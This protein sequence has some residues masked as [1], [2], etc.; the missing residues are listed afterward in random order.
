MKFTDY[1]YERPDINRFKEE[2]EMIL[3]KLM[4]ENN[5]NRF[6]KYFLEANKIF[7]NIET[8]FTLSK[9][10]NSLDVSDK[11]Y[12]DEIVFR[13]EN[14]PILDLY[15]AK[16]YRI[17]MSSKHKELLIKNYGE[18]IIEIARI[19]KST[20]SENI[21][22]ESEEENKLISSYGKL[23]ST[24]KV[25]YEG[26]DLR[27]SELGVY[28]TSPDRKI[29]KK[30]F[31]AFDNFFENKKNEFDYIYDSIIK[32]RNDMA[33]K[34]GYSNFVSLAYDRL[35]RYSYNQGDI[36]KHRELIKIYI[37]PLANTIIEEQKKELGFEKLYYYDENVMFLDSEAKLIVNEKN[38]INAA[39]E[40]YEEMSSET[41]EFF[42]YME[43]SKN[44]DLESRDN[45]KW[46]AFCAF[47]P[48]FKTPFVY[49][50]F[51]NTAEDV[52]LLT[53][54]MGHGFQMYRS[55][56]FDLPEYRFPT[57]DSC[58]VHSMSMEFLSYPFMDK[59]F[60]EDA[61]KFKFSHL[62]QYI[63]FIPYC[64]LIDDFQ[65]FIYEN[66][67]CT[68][69]ERNEYYKK[70]EK[71][72][73]PYRNYDDLTYFN[74]GR[75]YQK[76]G[77]LITDPMYYIDYSLALNVALQLFSEL[78]ENK[79]T[80]VNKYIKLCDIGGSKSFIELVKEAGLISP[81]DENSF[82]AINKEIQNKL[83]ELKKEI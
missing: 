78:E 3:E 42:D 59:F 79:E 46:G 54:E 24:G 50:N 72:Y 26:N 7:D 80:T 65:H 6:L 48:D 18:H 1:K 35:K 20:M 22:K 8:M 82:K 36:K 55:R 16:Y 31:K 15:R 17:I 27:F 41:K 19:S 39:K 77:H 38:I 81:F 2:I 12:N 70:I 21:L 62:T 60:G 49:G 32:L 76:Q 64:A 29:R 11:F 69:D 10:R 37:V 75:F 33:I 61:N 51:E 68:M 34:L 14:K 63:K 67:E 47:I 74:S 83:I 30:A 52:D 23:L 25:N 73:M 5:E 53:H 4:N 44:M 66:P 13:N 9:I 58:E 56:N 43:K 71:E 57:L 40:M 45:K 28:F